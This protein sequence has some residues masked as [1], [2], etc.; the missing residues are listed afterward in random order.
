MK[1]KFKY[2]VLLVLIAVCFIFAFSGCKDEEIKVSAEFYTL[3]EAYDNGWLDKSDLRNIAYYYYKFYKT[4]DPNGD[5][6]PIEPQELTEK[7]QK[8]LKLAYLERI[9]VTDGTIDK[10]D[11]YMNYGFYGNDIVVGITS[12][13]WMCDIIVEQEFDIGGVVFLDFW[14]GE[15]LVYHCSEIN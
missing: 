14:Q 6:E 2:Y 5:T 7:I 15:I 10:V 4:E 3:K 12:E 11:I 1:S 9:D 8:K 13:Y